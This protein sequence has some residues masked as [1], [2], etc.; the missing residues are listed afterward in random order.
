MEI[1][2]SE[3]R[4][5][6]V[7]WIKNWFDTKSGGKDCVAVLGMSGGKDSTICAALCAEALGPER[8]IGVMM[9]D[10]NQ[11]INEAD[12]ICKYLGIRYMKFPISRI[13]N[14]IRKTWEGMGFIQDDSKNP[15][16]G[17]LAGMTMSDQ[18]SQNIPPRIRMTVLFAIAQSN[19]GRV[20]CTDNASENYLGYSTFGGDDLGA[21]A[22]LGNLTVTEIRKLG[23]EMGIP[24]KWV[25]KVPDDGLPHSNSDEEKFGFTYETLDKFIKGAE[26]PDKEIVEKIGRMHASSEFKRQIIRV[27]SP[28]PVYSTTTK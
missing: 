12:E 5:E 6:I 18:T 27:P 20:C 26:M 15:M 28:D 10:N 8:V 16:F 25:H 11:G 1:N 14:A 2:I 3:T 19:N 24:T 23:D 21:F 13:T 9:P 7:N 17:I 4:K 22:P